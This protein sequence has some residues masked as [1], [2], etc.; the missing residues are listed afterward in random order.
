[1]AKYFGTDGIRGIA[2]IDLT[3]DLAYR[4]GR[5][6]ACSLKDSKQKTIIIGSDTRRSGDML[7]AALI[8]GITSEGFDVLDLGVIPTPGVAYL[9]V[10]Y[11]ASAGIVISASHNPS[12]YN[13][14]KFFGQDGFKLSDEKENE[15]EYLMDHIEKT[16][17]NLFGSDIGIV[18]KKGDA[19]DDY[20]NYLL[21][22][23]TIDLKGMKIAIDCANGATYK[24]APQLFSKLGAK[25][26]STAIE[27]NG[28]N[29]NNKCGSTFPELISKAVKETKADVGFAFDGDGDRIIVVDDKGKIMNGDHIL[30]ACGSYLKKIGKLKN[31]TIVGTIMSNIGLHKFCKKE[32]INLELTSV[33]DRYVLEKILEGDFSLGGE[34]SGHIIFIKDNT[35]GDGILS[36]IKVLEASLC[37]NQRISDLN[38]L[39][40]SYPQVL[41]N[42]KVNNGFKEKYEK[43]EEIQN[44]INELNDH[45]RGE[46]RV[47][48]RPSGTEPLVR[49]MIEGKNEDE[50]VTMAQDLVQLLEKHNERME[51]DE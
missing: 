41:M 3:P 32:N 17:Q 21:S 10:K 43:I 16:N 47:L 7:K 18:I 27:P 26:V 5:A 20:M 38:R 51:I 19:I 36:A 31:N 9:T 34:Q 11:M 29:I 2:N 15:I 12:E 37:Q 50:M 24:I 42:A 39:M 33:G 35:T 48:I 1:M 4:L 40:I 46:G 28:V 49:V 30:A 23:T 22:N 44:K 13:G 45:F 25:V 8:A 14:I 6:A